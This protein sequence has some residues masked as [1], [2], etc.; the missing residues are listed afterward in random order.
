LDIAHTMGTICG[1]AG[2][3][4]IGIAFDAYWIAS[5]SISGGNPHTSRTI[6]ALQWAV[7][8]DSNIYTKN[9]MPVVINCSWFD[10]SAEPC[11]NIYKQIFENLENLGIA[12]I[13]SAGNNGPG[14]STISAPQNTVI[15]KV[16]PF[17]VGN[18]DG[19]KYL[20]G[21]L[22]PIFNMSSRGPTT[23]SNDPELSIKPEVCAPGVDI[24]SSI[25]VNNYAKMTGTS[26]A[27]PHVSG[28][29]ALLKQAFPYKSPYLIKEAIYSSAKDL[30]PIGKD[31]SYGMRLVDAY[32]AAKLLDNRIP[33]T[34]ITDLSLIKVRSNSA[35]IK[36]TTPFDSSFDGI[37][38]Y[39]IRI[40]N[41]PIDQ[42]NFNQAQKLFYNK[43][44]KL[45]Y[46]SDTLV[47]ENLQPNT[48]YYVA[49]KSFDVW[50]NISELSYVLAFTTLGYPQIQLTKKSFTR[51][52][53]IDN[54]LDIADTIEIK[55]ISNNASYLEGNISLFEVNFDLS[56]NFHLLKTQK[57]LALIIY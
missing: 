30:G 8:P 7:N 55:N 12:V 34:K 41:N 20:N 38:G 32:A 1:K 19:T 2:T 25:P 4:T 5:N 35:I 52:F 16:N 10:A 56:N 42:D 46:T 51:T 33:P 45:P 23:C 11:N 18:L 21:D 50:E 57:L 17:T 14:N 6:A 27:A 53:T 54:Y 47:I 9:D 15:N 29:Y 26:I 24:I 40:S 48:T 44:P 36:W 31:N 39:D 37:Y 22:N 13:F 28:V 49:I 43:S 3:D